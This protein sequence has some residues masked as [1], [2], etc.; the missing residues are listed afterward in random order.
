[1][2]RRIT[3]RIED[4]VEAALAEQNT[5]PGEQVTWDSSFALTPDGPT[6]LMVFFMPGPVLGST[7]QTV[8]MLQHVQSAT[9]FDLTETVRNVL[10]H[11]R[12]ER[13]KALSDPDGQPT[14]FPGLQMAAGAQEG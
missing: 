9:E 14:L 4:W 3:T 1:M 12:Q 13:S 8:V 11:L 2:S 7:V 5:A 6:M 10:E